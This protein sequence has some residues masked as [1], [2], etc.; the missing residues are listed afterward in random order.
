MISTLAAKLTVKAVLWAENLAQ[1]AHKPFVVAETK[2]RGLVIAFTQDPTVRAYLD[3][4]NMILM[5]AIFR[6]AAHAR[7]MRGRCVNLWLP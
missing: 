7:P 5:N 4:L 2:G 3:G 1:L 6:G